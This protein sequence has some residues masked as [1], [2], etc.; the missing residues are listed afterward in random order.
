MFG[1]VWKASY[2]RIVLYLLAGVAAFRIGAALCTAGEGDVIT[3][4]G[5]RDLWRALTFGP[6]WPTSGPEINGGL[7]PPG[8]AFY[9]LL[10][11]ILA[12]QPSLHAASIGMFALFAASVG[13]LGLIV[14]REMTPRVGVLAAVVLAGSPML[15]QVLQ[16]WNPGYLLFFATLATLFGYRYVKNGRAPA[17]GI[18]AAAVAIG[19]QIHLQMFQLAVALAIAM[20]VRRPGWT[21]R[22]GLAVVL[23]LGLPYLPAMLGG[24]LHLLAAAAT[25]PA[26]AVDNYVLW[27]FH[28][29]EKA[30]LIYGLLGGTPVS[31]GPDAG[32]RL[33]IPAMLGDLLAA[34]LSLG[35]CGWAIG[36]IGRLRIGREGVSARTGQ[37]LGVFALIMA[38]YLLV[39]LGSTV[40]ARHMVAAWPAIAVMTAVAADAVLRRLASWR[41]R[42][43]AVAGCAVLLCGLAV[44]PLALGAISLQAPVF[45]LGS[46]AA[47][48]EIAATAKS[49]FYADHEAFDAHAALFWRPESRAWQLIQEGVSGQM[50]FIYHTT[51]AGLVGSDRAE[52]LA[53]VEKD[54]MTGG[55]VRAELAKSPAFAGLAPVFA[56]MAA[57]SAHFAYFPYVTADGNCLKSFPNAYIP[58]RF[59]T[60]YLPTGAAAGATQSSDAAQFV[61]ALPG[62]IFPLGLELRRSGTDYRA[63]LHGR[64]LRGYTGLYFATILNP[65]LCL[66]GDTGVRVVPVGRLTVGSPQRGSLAP[67][68][69]PHFA[70]P[71]GRYRL[72]LVGRN[73]KSPQAIQIPLGLVD[74]PGMHA[75]VP[76]AG[77]AA[78]PVGCPVPI[79]ASSG[80][81][82]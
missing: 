6:S 74:L 8:G 25:V 20:L 3:V 5:D 22:H 64:L 58:T 78:P 10:R 46:A 18:A 17:L 12:I 29:L 33:A 67:W 19:L 42:R 7:R 39:G 55:D 43:L 81:A 50:T 56:P 1:G 41:R 49:A 45:S 32:G 69:S 28:P 13:L 31:T 59:E 34:L 38:V 77:E 44:R 27:E 75:E 82:G 4:W 51:P 53:I 2:G 40:N 80:G 73:G 21:W 68:Q 76:A 62:Q 65:V 11:G 15:G 47:Q 71:D 61:A 57:E 66:A 79:L 52:C 35:F 36:S 37:P 16:V 23:G 70:L 60:A 63:V 30:Q 72:W 9:F 54:Q 26:G 14:G 48:A 24:E